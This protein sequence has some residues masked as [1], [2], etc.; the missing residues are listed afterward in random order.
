MWDKLK[1]VFGVAA[2]EREML[3]S[4]NLVALM[5]AQAV[6]KIGEQGIGVVDSV[7]CLLAMQ[8]GTRSELHLISE[9]WLASPDYALEPDVGSR[10][11]SYR[12]YENSRGDVAVMSCAVEQAGWSDRGQLDPARYGIYLCIKLG[13]DP[14]KLRS[15]FVRVKF[16]S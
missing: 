8:H 11:A 6:K 9:P 16:R 3:R 10:V 15:G 2:S 5:N 13:L 14:K 12:I 1:S 7:T 4:P